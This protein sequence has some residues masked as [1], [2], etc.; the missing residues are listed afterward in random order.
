MKKLLFSLLMLTAAPWTFSQSIE[1]VYA[2][3][4]N[5]M[6]SSQAFTVKAATCGPDTIGY[7]LAKAT[8]LEALN[9]NNATSA[10]AVGQYFDAPQPITISGVSFYAWKPDATAGITMNVTVEVYAAAL[11][12]TPTG[13]ALATT[14]S[15]VDTVFGAGTLTALRKHATFTT[16]ITVSGSYVVVITNASATPLSM[17]FNS[18]A[19][20]DG[21]QEWLSSVSIAA[22]WL[23]SYNVNVGGTTFDAD[24]LFEP[25][26]TYSMAANFIPS[27]QCMTT[28]PTI[29]FTNT[30]SPVLNNRMYNQAAYLASTD[31]SY[32]WDYGDG[33]GTEV[34]ENPIHAFPTNVGPYSVLLRDTLFGW[35]S[36]CAA[37]TTIVLGAS[38]T[39]AYTAVPSGSTVTFTDGSTSSVSV[40]SWFWDF[41]DGNT[42]TQQNPI[43]SYAS[44]GTYTVCLTATNNCGFT[45]STC[46]SV[47]VTSCTGPISA[48]TFIDAGLA[49]SFTDA[50][51]STAPPATYL[52]DFGD[53]NTSSLQN[54][55]HT[56]SADGTYTVCLL[57]VDQCDADTICQ[58]VTVSSCVVPTAGFT[59][60][61]S[62]PTYTFT[63]TSTTT[64]I[65]T[66]LWDFG[67][68][69]S[70]TL[71]DPSHTYTSNG[72]FTVVLTVTDSCGINS[73][74][75][76]V[77]NSAVGIDELQLSSAIIF[78]NP[79][80]D[81]VTF[82]SE[83]GMDLV[84]LIDG[85]GR[86]V[87]SISVNGNVETTL[88]MRSYAE[89]NYSVRITFSSG[90]T[91]LMRISVVR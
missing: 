7:T 29:S 77:T 90:S 18:W 48:Y 13:M 87:A 73:F 74:T 79:S 53:G 9:I 38:L 84:E 39:P 36:T 62:E 78:P 1:A 72:T 2:T 45:D 57:L 85:S 37:D 43:H 16:P 82:S 64:G 20:A 70:S 24:C 63:N 52:W 33:S 22:S 11:D 6:T 46:Q 68:G 14:T 54:P 83:N 66:Y 89:G 69:N 23:R 59:I 91:D 56:Y 61:G 40:A 80:N 88:D 12:S 65:A 55:I 3:L 32:T 58:T 30:S 5:D 86:L 81:Q 47:T 17:V 41:G 28:G 15:L 31:L 67:D 75:Q 35:T 10:D 51:T 34:L 44:V 71:S 42:S 8:G 76:T 50:S 19:A 27:D 25:H 21:G 49:V 26:T 4:I 60:G